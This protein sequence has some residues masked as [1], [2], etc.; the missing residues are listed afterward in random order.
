MSEPF[1]LTEK[2]GWFYVVDA[3]GCDFEYSGPWR[4]REDAQQYC[5]ELNG[6]K[7]PSGRGNG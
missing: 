7:Q 1:R 2:N 3:D 4:Y 6:V 5:D